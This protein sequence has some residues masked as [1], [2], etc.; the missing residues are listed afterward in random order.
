M[1][2]VSLSRSSPDQSSVCSRSQHVLV[3][4]KQTHPLPPQLQQLKQRKSLRNLRHR[5]PQRILT[6]QSLQT[7]SRWALNLL[8]PR[9]LPPRLLLLSQL[10]QPS[11]RPLKPKLLDLRS[12]ESR[13]G[14]E[15]RKR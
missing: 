3:T 13:V 5:T 9:Q 4:L 6:L 15:G 7:P 10:P 12:E 14:K 11:P 8:M 1:K 2:A